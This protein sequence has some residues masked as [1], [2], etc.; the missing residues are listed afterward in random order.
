VPVP[1]LGLGLGGSL[2]LDLGAIRAP[3]VEG[4]RPDE[5]GRKPP[6]PPAAIVARLKAQ[7][8]AAAA[9]G[10]AAAAAAPPPATAPGAAA[11]ALEGMAGPSLTRALSEMSVA[12]ISTALAAT[13]RS[14]FGM[15]ASW[16]IDA[17]EIR[18]RERLGAGAFSP[19]LPDLLGPPRP[20]S[21]C[22]ISPRSPPQVRTARSLRPSGGGAVSRSSGSAL[23][24]TLS[25][26]W[27]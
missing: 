11:A 12:D 5:E 19:D 14:L 18:F 26:P 25:S 8:E 1:A 15:G 27:P 7:A 10:G 23:T 21:T 6:T 3:K 4:D 17:S 24:P 20:S 13:N 9:G 2:K 16:A 22:S